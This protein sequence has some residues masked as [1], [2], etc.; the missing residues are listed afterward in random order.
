MRRRREEK[1]PVVQAIGTAVGTSRL[2]LY[3]K[4]SSARTKADRYVFLVD[5]LENGKD[6]TRKWKGVSEFMNLNTGITRS[7]E[8]FWYIF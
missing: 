2:I 7:Y 6:W 1:K 5:T 4:H 8:N 3:E